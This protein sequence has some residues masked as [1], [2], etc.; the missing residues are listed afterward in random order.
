VVRQQQ[1]EEAALAPEVQDR[2]RNA[3]QDAVEGKRREPIE[4]RRRG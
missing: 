2:A 3:D 4:K 1:G